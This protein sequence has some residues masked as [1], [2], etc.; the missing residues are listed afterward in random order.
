MSSSAFALRLAT[1]PV[2]DLTLEQIARD[3]ARR[4]LQQAIEN[5]VADYIEAHQHHVDGSGHRL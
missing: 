2:V 3:G 5:E 4:Y 1:E